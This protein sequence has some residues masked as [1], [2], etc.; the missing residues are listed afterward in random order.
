MGIGPYTEVSVPS[1]D[2]AIR[3]PPLPKEPALS[4]ETYHPTTASQGESKKSLSR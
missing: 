3:A 1:V 4:G 2:P